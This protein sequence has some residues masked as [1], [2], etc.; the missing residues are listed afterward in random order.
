M[1]GFIRR[2][3][4]AATMT[5]VWPAVMALAVLLVLAACGGKKTAGTEPAPPPTTAPP[6]TTAAPPAPTPL[7]VYLPPDGRVAPAGREVT[8]TQA[9]ASAALRALI[10]G[11]TAE[12]GRA[13]LTSSIPA[14]TQLRGLSIAGGVATVDLSHEF[15]SGGGS[16]S[17]TTRV[18][19]VVYTLTQFPS[20]DRVAFRIDGAAVRAIG[21]RGVVVDPPVSPP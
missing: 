10:E 12:E 3:G 17:L 13:G 9:V 16:P 15:E 14:G 5:R 18:A 2:G 1:T 8:Q 7:R 19:Q 20:V 4:Y 21:G 11:P 6:A